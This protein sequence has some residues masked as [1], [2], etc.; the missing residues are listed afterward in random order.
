MITKIEV[1]LYYRIFFLF[2]SLLSMRIFFTIGNC[3]LFKNHTPSIFILIPAFSPQSHLMSKLTKVQPG[4]WW[5]HQ[6]VVAEVWFQDHIYP[7]QSSEIPIR[8]STFKHSIY[9]KKEFWVGQHEKLREISKKQA[10]KSKLSWKCLLKR[11]ICSPH[12]NLSYIIK[13]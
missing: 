8:S 2:R 10:N 6:L 12:I 9:Q 5:L 13:G 4:Y 3:Y 1:F 11:E 7:K